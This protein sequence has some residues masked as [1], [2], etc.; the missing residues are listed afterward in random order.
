MND[1]TVPAANL[2]CGGAS[3]FA[4]HQDDRRRHDQRACYPGNRL[5]KLPL[6]SSFLSPGIQNEESRGEDD[7]N[8]QSKTRL[9]EGNIAT[10]D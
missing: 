1:L 6:G 5:L 7:V 3:Q 2:F 9:A 4:P 10:K 8:D